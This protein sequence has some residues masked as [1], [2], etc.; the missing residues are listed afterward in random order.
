MARPG[1]GAQEPGSE[2][3]A[4]QSVQAV[5]QHDAA[6]GERPA[7]TPRRTPTCKSAR[8]ERHPARRGRPGAGRPGGRRARVRARRAR[9]AYAM[10]PAGESWPNGRSARPMHRCRKPPCWR[11]PPSSRKSG[12][13]LS[14]AASVPPIKVQRGDTLARILARLGAQSWQVRAM[15]E[16][17]RAAYSPRPRCCRASRFAPSSCRRPARPSRRSPSASACSTRRA[18]QGHRHAQCRRR[19]RAER[20]ADRRA[21]RRC[22]CS[23]KATRRRTTASMP[24]CI[25]PPQSRAFR[26]DLIHADHAHPRLRRPTSASGCGPAT[27]SNS[28]ST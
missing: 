4:V 2:H 8:A 20:H 9:R 7:R 11:K 28:S 16:A 14:P 17:A 18:P 3:P 27:A 23:A 12:R 22:G 1:A 15:I 21:D 6:R 19:V 5:R 26:A 13:R 24:A 25:T 10:P